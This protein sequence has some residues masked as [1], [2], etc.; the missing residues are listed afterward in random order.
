MSDAVLA[1]PSPSAIREDLQD[2]IVGELL[3]PA[4]GPDEE[5][6]EERLTERYILGMLAPRGELAS[7]DEQDRRIGIGPGRTKSVFS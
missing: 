5:V 4:G 7:P 6:T 1:P 3:G 2:L